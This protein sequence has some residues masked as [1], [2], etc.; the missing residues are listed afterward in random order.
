ME[1]TPSWQEL[2]VISY[3]CTLGCEKIREIVSSEPVAIRYICDI[4]FNEFCSSKSELVMK[5]CLI[6]LHTATFYQHVSKKQK[7]VSGI[8]S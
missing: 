1:D 2:Y 8:N 7:Q 3:I 4:D 5:P 6:S